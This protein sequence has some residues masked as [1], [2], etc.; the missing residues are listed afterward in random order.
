M[1]IYY[2]KVH[3]SLFPA[4]PTPTET[5]LPHLIC[6][7]CMDYV[8]IL[9]IYGYIPFPKINHHYAITDM[10]SALRSDFLVIAVGGKG[11][12]YK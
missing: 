1:S 4:V 11:A 5:A 12:G 7:I 10:C 2:A 9:Y 6:A 8:H 3:K